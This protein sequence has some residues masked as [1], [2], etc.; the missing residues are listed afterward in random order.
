MLL[1]RIALAV[2]I[3]VTFTAGVAEVVTARSDGEPQ[4]TENTSASVE[5]QLRRTR[6]AEPIFLTPRA[7]ASSGGGNPGDDARPRAAGDQA[8]PVE[9]REPSLLCAGSAAIP[10][11]EVPHEHV[12]RVAAIN[13]DGGTAPMSVARGEIGTKGQRRHVTRLANVVECLDADIVVVSEVHRHTLHW[14]EVDMFRRLGRELGEGWNGVFE[15][16]CRVPRRSG[17]RG[18]A[19]GVAVFSN[20][21]RSGGPMTKGFVRTDSGDRSLGVPLPVRLPNSDRYPGGWKEQ[22]NLCYWTPDKER[23]QG[24]RQR[25]ALVA[26][27]HGIEVV[28]LHLSPG[29]DN[30]RL[31][32]HQ[33]R[34]LSQRL[35]DIAPQFDRAL[36]GGE[37]PMLVAGDLNEDDCLFDNRCAP[38]WK[39]SFV[40]FFGPGWIN[41]DTLLDSTHSRGVKI[42]HV[43]IRDIAPVSSES[44]GEIARTLDVGFLRHHV[45]YVDTL[46][47]GRSGP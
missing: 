5:S 44:N 35:A 46:R 3:T 17:G 36:G 19:V 20:D 31:R 1:S 15:P 38:E 24:G 47:P 43:L 27:T 12:L 41:T 6:A 16:Q 23:R 10:K 21:A 30:G 22:R 29:A 14:P 25:V 42:D 8:D 34:E 39:K 2:T 26:A 45:L 28:G 4:A 13:A 7:G 37:R 33:L 40:D 11:P 9:E 18:G 32:R